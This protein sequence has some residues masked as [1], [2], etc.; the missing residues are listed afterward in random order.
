MVLSCQEITEMI[1]VRY[2]DFPDLIRGS[3]Q[4]DADGNFNVSINNRLSESQKKRT[5]DHELRHIRL[6]HFD[7]ELTDRTTKEKQASTAPQ[8]PK[9]GQK[10]LRSA[11]HWN[12]AGWQKIE[13]I[14]LLH[15]IQSGCGT[16][17]GSLHQGTD[18]SD[19]TD[20]YFV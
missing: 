17:D 8:K 9:S 7:D 11:R 12:N 15:D 2:I 18:P 3:V 10:V 6:G 16:E 4:I 5:L 20:L 14:V 1:F 13:E 19:P